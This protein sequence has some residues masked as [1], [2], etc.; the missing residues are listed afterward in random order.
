MAPCHDYTCFN[1]NIPSFCLSQS[2]FLF[3][4]SSASGCSS[5]NGVCCGSSRNGH[6]H[7]WITGRGL[8]TVDSDER[9]R[10]RGKE[11]GGGQ[12][13]SLP[14]REKKKKMWGKE[15]GMKRKDGRILFHAVIMMKSFHS[16]CD[17]GGFLSS[18]YVK[19]LDGFNANIIPHTHFCSCDRI[20]METC[21]K[22][23][24]LWVLK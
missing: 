16:V 6:Y 4:F 22:P 5:S 7:P 11:R 19:P 10:G 13:G 21:F 15:K 8:H 2:F 1:Q 3:L 23:T 24:E 17:D 20:W 9:G 14:L 12:K 18:S